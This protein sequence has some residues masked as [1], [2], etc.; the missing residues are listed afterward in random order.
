MNSSSTLLI[1][2]A[3]LTSFGLA[4]EAN[5]IANGCQKDSDCVL[6]MDPCRKLSSV[7]KASL[8]PEDGLVKDN[9]SLLKDN[10]VYSSGEFSDD[11]LGYFPPQWPKHP[12]ARC[13]NGVCSLSE[14][15]LKQPIR[16]PKF[17]RKHGSP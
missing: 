1:L 16:K 15:T 8:H 17:K 2:A 11:C 5:R 9:E 7:L 4:A 10:D 14:A 3:I 13:S 6:F 12:V